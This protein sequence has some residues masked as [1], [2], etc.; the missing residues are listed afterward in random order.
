[1]PCKKCQL[2][3]QHIIVIY[4]ENQP[5]NPPCFMAL[6][7]AILHR[8]KE[9]PASCPMSCWEQGSSAFT[10]C[11]SS[12]CCPKHYPVVVSWFIAPLFGRLWCWTVRIFHES[13]LFSLKYVFPLNRFFQVLFHDDQS[14]AGFVKWLICSPALEDL[15]EN[16]L[17]IRALPTAPEECPSSMVR[18]R[19]NTHG[20]FYCSCNLWAHPDIVR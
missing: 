19:R 3:A 14:W 10:W 1:M 6:D 12:P 5:E 15:W 17:S 7:E 2:S 20:N 4:R 13:L 18:P 11:P 9:S 16:T 8:H